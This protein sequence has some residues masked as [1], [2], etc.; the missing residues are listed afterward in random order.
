M[1]ERTWETDSDASHPIIPNLEMNWEH[2]HCLADGNQ[3]F[4]LELLHL[5]LEDTQVHLER[6]RFAIVNQDF[7]LLEQEAHHMKGASANVGATPIRTAA[8]QL[9]QQGKQQQLADA[10][11]LLAEIEAALRLIQTYVETAS[12]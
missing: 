11:D 3:E 12:P 1:S 10:T 4:E 7:A 6:A 9:E 8:T 2:L 5:F